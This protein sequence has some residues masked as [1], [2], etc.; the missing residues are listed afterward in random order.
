MS[1]QISS[2]RAQAELLAHILVYGSVGTA[3]SAVVYFLHD[4]IR[5]LHQWRSMIDNGRKLSEM[6]RK[7]GFSESNLRRLKNTSLETY[8]LDQQARGN[9]RLE[10]IDDIPKWTSS[11]HRGQIYHVVTISPR[12]PKKKASRERKAIDIQPVFDRDIVSPNARSLRSEFLECRDSFRHTQHGNLFQ[13]RSHQ[14]LPVFRTMSS[15]H[16]YRLICSD[17]R[18]HGSG[19]LYLLANGAYQRSAARSFIT[20]KATGMEYSAHRTFSANSDTIPNGPQHLSSDS[21]KERCIQFLSKYEVN[22]SPRESELDM[23]AISKAVLQIASDSPAGSWT[24]RAVTPLLSELIILGHLALSD[25][26]SQL[27]S[28][29]SFILLLQ[30]VQQHRHTASND[31]QVVVFAYN[32]FF[33]L[34]TTARASR[35]WLRTMSRTLIQ[36]VKPESLLVMCGDHFSSSSSEKVLDLFLPS[37]FR[38]ACEDS[39]VYITHLEQMLRY[40]N[41]VLPREAFENV[42]LNCLKHSPS[43][44]DSV[45][46][47]VINVILKDI[48]FEYG[49]E[50]KASEQ[51]SERK[52]QITSDLLVIALEQNCWETAVQILEQ[53]SD[54][55]DS[56]QLDQASIFLISQYHTFL[57][58][59]S[60][61]TVG[62]KIL[63]LYS[64]RIITA[65]KDDIARIVKDYYSLSSVPYQLRSKFLQDAVAILGFDL[66]SVTNILSPSSNPKDQEMADVLLQRQ[67]DHI[68]SIWKSKGDI[69]KVSE[70]YRDFNQVASSPNIVMTQ[71]FLRIAIEAGNTSLMSS[72]AWNFY[73]KSPEARSN[74][75]DMLLILSALAKCGQT[76]DLTRILDDVDVSK[77]LSG[78][79]NRIIAH[80]DIYVDIA[81]TVPC[82]QALDFIETCYEKY[83]FT[84]GPLAFNILL[85]HI[86]AEE[87]LG[88]CVKLAQR[89]LELDSRQKHPVGVTKHN[90]AIAMR[91]ARSRR[92]GDAPF[93][94]YLLKMIDSANSS[95][96]SKNLCLELTEWLAVDSRGTER[97]IHKTRPHLHGKFWSSSQMARLR[98]LKFLLRA[99]T[100]RHIADRSK[101]LSKIPHFHPYF[102]RRVFPTSESEARLYE[103]KSL[104]CRVLMQRFLALGDAEAAVKAFE[105]FMIEHNT[106]SRRLTEI[107]VSAYLR[108][109]D[110]DRAQ[111]ITKQLNKSGLKSAAVELLRVRDNI[112][113]GQ[114]AVTGLRKL[115]AEWYRSFS[116]Q[117]PRF[118]H[119]PL[120]DAINHLLYPTT[121]EVTADP[122][123]AVQLLLEMYNSPPM[124]SV[125]PGIEVYIAFFSAYAANKDIHG[126]I[127]TFLKIF[128][129]N[130]TLTPQFFRA[131]KNRSE[132]MIQDMKKNRDERLYEVR[133]LLF[134]IKKLCQQRKKQQKLQDRVT[135]KGVFNILLQNSRGFQP[136]QP[137]ISK[138][139]HSN[140]HLDTG[141]S[142]ETKSI[143]GEHN[144][145]GSAKYPLPTN[146][147]MRQGLER[148]NALTFAA[149]SEKA[150][151]PEILELIPEAKNVA[152]SP[153]L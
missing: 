30:L 86:T 112:H 94:F 53:Y 65:E 62:V 68:W 141:P 32:A 151:T 111:N 56:K 78:H 9:I 133:L 44:S 16:Q 75:D 107:A 51:T 21:L 27:H 90:M 5:Q 23:A 119:R 100:V 139:S 113:K 11:P 55:L 60:K 40:L 130:L 22:K 48:P 77:L 83:G 150:S 74:W 15:Q 115:I 126:I 93:N 131:L 88:S 127:W 96:I 13:P 149:L 80:C 129:D 36:V 114:L 134:H 110:T 42:I 61:P 116:L 50:V 31:E 79:P 82:E 97:V 85:F 34:V 143:S 58:Y 47:L 7:H 25:A 3:S 147:L 146:A 20:R 28:S 52:N 128:Q 67:I 89:L 63:E 17:T 92:A 57:Q 152:K 43:M 72:T 41:G 144:V 117:K 37:L 1:R 102:E 99:S 138:E 49:T 81:K 59:D 142:M 121:P 29:S 33:S 70:F 140:D 66:D 95:L 54:A 4:Q 137:E 109:G 76:T 125:P 38:L 6:A 10:L 98:Q 103:E 69:S 106:P 64:R 148:L 35:A 136:T 124:K 118:L 24:L 19:R 12:P 122:P 104:L 87:E 145:S 105:A 39:Q 120:C 84:L 14:S 132:H 26:V 108:L 45:L 71:N 135:L 18:R 73:E 101:W 2:V 8:L 91:G 123:A 46:C 153:K